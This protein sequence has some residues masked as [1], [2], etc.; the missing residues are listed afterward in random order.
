MAKAAQTPVQFNYER[1]T[2]Q[3]DIM[4]AA[5][6]VVIL[7]VMLVPIPPAFIDLMLTFSISISLVV[8]VTSMFMGSPLEFSIYPTLLLVTTLLRLSMNVASTRLILLHGDEGPSAAG[9]VIQAFGQFVVGGNYVVG[10]VIFL[11]L[12]A[13]NKKVIVAGTTRIAEVAA[14]FTLDAMPG[15]QMAIEADL[16]AGL[17]NEKQATERRD[18]IRKEADFYGA[19]DGAGKFVSGDVTATIIIT[20]I[21]IF[22]GFFIGVLQKGMNWKDAAQTYTLLT[23]GD[24]LVSI[25]PSI[26]ISTSA[27]LIVSRAAA[28]AKMGEEFLAQLTFHPRA[29]R[30]V[31][32]MLF[33]FGIVPG[34]PTFPFFAMSILLFFV[35]RLSGKQQELL[36]GQAA[37]Q[38]KKPAPELE[39]PEEV[40]TLLPLDALELEVGYGLIPLVDEE[41]NGN[42]LARIRSI[43]R[44]F[45]LDMGVV[46]PSLHLRDNLQLRPGQY[47]VLIK[48]NE[49]ASAE[50]LIDHYLAMDPGDAKHRIQGVETREPAFNLPALWV[51]EL[52]KEEAMLAGYTVVDPATVIAT[53]LT[54]VFKRHLHE[55]LGRQ[56]VQ[57]LLETLSKR[58]PKVVEELVPGAMNLGGV[59]KVL[60]NLV[61]EGV[62]IRDLLTVAETM[63][64]YAGSVKDPDQLTEY[65]RSRMGRTIVKPYLTGEGALPIM[66]LAPKVEGAVQESV[67]QTD[68]GAYLAMEP[69]LAQRIIQAI[70]K[71]M[72]KAMLGDGQPVLLTS[73]LVRPHLAQ[74]LSRFIPNLPVISQAEIPAEIKLQS[75][76][77]I[78]LTN[79][80]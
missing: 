43:R 32:G 64:D 50:I 41:Q 75:I 38:E 52:H 71:A 79:A 28:E 78:G 33:L 59:Q 68:H 73:P 19:M 26:I 13:I 21:N 20:A 15:K 45:A 66:T 53:H 60:Q 11:V 24:G 77:N 72:D 80:G 55:F 17:I 36:Q 69:G 16:N 40:Q 39:T 10:C 23:I 51:P 35:A 1:F 76:A 4:L 63:A 42:L 47:V 54:E 62:S 7:F 22:G 34:L 65:V 25:I 56:E 18:A 5:G 14:R 37:E 44:Q 29:L 48:G 3:G 12:F 6:V 2:K 46:I 8:L 74:L 27:G 31:S 49:V 30:L 58:A 61:R 9:H 70:Q 57:T 67:R